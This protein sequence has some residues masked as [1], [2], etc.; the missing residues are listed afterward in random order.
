MLKYFCVA[1][2]TQAIKLLTNAHQNEGWRVLQIH[3]RMLAQFDHLQKV[4][5]LNIMCVYLHIQNHNLNRSAGL[6]AVHIDLV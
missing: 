3:F 1:L 4:I 6:M 2:F 5:Y